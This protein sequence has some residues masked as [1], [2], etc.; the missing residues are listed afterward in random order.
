M[1]SIN[2]AAM[3]N[4]VMNLS[5]SKVPENREVPYL[6]PCRRAS[7]LESVFLFLT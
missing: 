6:T 4:N 7:N 3:E 1:N 5:V 2:D